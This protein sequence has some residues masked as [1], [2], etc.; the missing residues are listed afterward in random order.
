MQRFCYSGFESSVDKSEVENILEGSTFEVDAFRLLLELNS[1]FRPC[2]SVRQEWVQLC[3]DL[4]LVQSETRFL[5]FDVHLDVLGVISTIAQR[6]Q[7]SLVFR[8][9]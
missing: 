3:R 7:I 9:R 1:L 8:V 5:F 4:S 2:N 6:Y